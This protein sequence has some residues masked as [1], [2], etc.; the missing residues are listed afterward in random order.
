[1]KA[2]TTAKEIKQLAEKLGGYEELAV[3]C[4]VRH[5]T[6]YKWVKGTK[7]HKANMIVLQGLMD[8]VDRAGESL[9]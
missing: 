5:Q 4:H 2:D 9:K 3:K 1:M 6:V 7:P 8:E